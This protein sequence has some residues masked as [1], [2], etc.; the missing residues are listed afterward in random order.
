MKTQIRS[1]LAVFLIVSIIGCAKKQ[2]ETANSQQNNSTNSATPNTSATSGNKTPGVAIPAKTLAGMLPAVPGY[3]AKGEP[4]TMEMEMS[5]TKYSHAMQTY[6]NGDKQI[7]VSILDYNYI[8]GLS[9]AYT[10][11]MNMSLETN[12]ESMHADK[13]GGNPGWIDWKKNSNEGT[14]GVVVNDRVFVIVEGRGGATAD[15]IKSVAN[16]INYSNIAS[17]IK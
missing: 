5:G 12:E 15:E 13:F 7:K 11:M 6:Q 16:N 8:A 1:L 17:A 4:E 2:E 10:A 3:T 14:V 9:M